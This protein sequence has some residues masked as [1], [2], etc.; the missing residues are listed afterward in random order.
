M[1]HT[2]QKRT[3]SPISCHYLCMWPES[4]KS[5]IWESGHSLQIFLKKLHKF[6]HNCVFLA[7]KW[8]YLDFNEISVIFFRIFFNNFS[9]TCKFQR[10]WLKKNQWFHASL[11]H[12]TNLPQEPGSSV[13]HVIQTLVVTFFVMFGHCNNIIIIYM[14][15]VCTQPENI[16]P[17][18]LLFVIGLIPTDL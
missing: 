17:D 11:P 2:N 7:Y 14:E 9:K 15:W 16:P 10:N 4:N 5:Q 13:P 1:F 3:S 18:K 8:T 6:A 12:F